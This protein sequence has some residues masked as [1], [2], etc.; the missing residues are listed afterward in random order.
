[1]TRTVPAT[2]QGP[3]HAQVTP[4][5]LLNPRDDETFGRVVSAWRPTVWE[6]ARLQRY[7][8][9]RYPD[10]VVRLRDLTGEDRLVWYVYRDGVWVNTSRRE[11]RRPFGRGGRSG[12]TATGRRRGRPPLPGSG[13]H[14]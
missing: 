8:R 6:P 3:L 1:M 14:R 7:L 5:L 4:E 10:A 13:V 9:D 2:S 12:R 11:D